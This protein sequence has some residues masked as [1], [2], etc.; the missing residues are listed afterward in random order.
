M[1]IHPITIANRT[2]SY[3]DYRDKFFFSVPCQ[4]CSSCTLANQSD[5]FIRS[6]YHFKEYPYVYIYTLTYNNE[7]L[8][9]F[10]SKL[11]PE[12]I[13]LPCFNQ[14]HIKS[15]ID[16]LRKYLIRHRLCSNK[17]FTFLVCSEYGKDPNGTRRPHYHCE[18]FFKHKLPFRQLHSLMRQFW[19][20][21]YG[22][23]YPD[24]KVK[25]ELRNSKLYRETYPPESA[26][27]ALDIEK[28]SRYCSKYVTKDINFFNQPLVSRFLDK[29]LDKYTYNTRYNEIK[30]YL[31]KHWQSRGFGL[32]MLEEVKS[33]PDYYL[34]GGKLHLLSRS[35][36]KQDSK[37]IRIPAYILDKIK[38]NIVRYDNR[39]FG[40][41][42]L[43][44]SD[45]RTKNKYIRIRV[46]TEF[47]RNFVKRNFSN[48]YNQLTDYVRKGI[49]ILSQDSEALRLANLGNY[50]WNSSVRDF[51]KS[52]S[53][54]SLV[55]YSLF[56]RDRQVL[57]DSDP[58][59]SFIGGVTD[60]DFSQAYDF[61][62][63]IQKPRSNNIWS[64]APR[65]C[66]VYNSLPEYSLYECLFQALEK[67]YSWL[68]SYQSEKLLELQEFYRQM[69]RYRKGFVV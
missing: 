52:V 34:G 1:C 13:D 44:D 49:Q 19:A 36:G 47:Y 50:C 53:L 10:S 38:Y 23:I 64:F 37:K 17:D 8:P 68:Y 57:S 22:F 48:K 45:S 61:F 26:V 35:K 32:A 6:Y 21:K 55:N 27:L 5:W 29:S 40:L 51:A 16:L 56:L 12:F 33:N 43:Y 58:L 39:Y 59:H 69:K 54:S 9:K 24:V 30:P 31:P 7:N 63:K 14:H 2:R 3:T 28:C 65:R 4:K 60:F 42:G 18:L 11:Y 66:K 20:D 15:T 25:S 62:C 46:M 41:G 67:L